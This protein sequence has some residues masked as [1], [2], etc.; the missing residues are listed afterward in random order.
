M[1]ASASEQASAA[2]LNNHS[3][4][5]ERRRHTVIT[6]VSDVCSFQENE[7]VLKVD[8]GLMILTGEGLHMAKLL[9]EDGKLQIEGKVDSMVYEQPRKSFRL[10]QWWKHGKKGN[11][12]E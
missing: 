6:G 4:Q 10:S 8:T 9:L 2:R 5:M 3:V 12:R 11:V 7:V 1:A